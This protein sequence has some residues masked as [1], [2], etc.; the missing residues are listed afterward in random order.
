MRHCDQLDTVRH[1]EEVTM[2]KELAARGGLYRTMQIKDGTIRK[3]RETHPVAGVRATV[4]SGSAL[5]SRVTV[6]R[7]LA[8]GLFAL[9]AKKTRGGEMW[10]LV[11]GPDFAWTVE[12]DRKDIAAARHFAAFVNQAARA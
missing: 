8:V 11:E 12:V 5:Q 7:L 6:T 10:L 2:M 3:G 9:A 1:T 4:E